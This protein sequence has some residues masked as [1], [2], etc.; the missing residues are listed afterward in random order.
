MFGGLGGFVQDQ[1]FGKQQIFNESGELYGFVSNNKIE[2]YWQYP[3]NFPVSDGKNCSVPYEKNSDDGV[4]IYS[5]DCE[6]YWSTKSIKIPPFTTIYQESYSKVNIHSFNVLK[7]IAN[8]LNINL[9]ISHT[10]YENGRYIGIFNKVNKYYTIISVD[11]IHYEVR[12]LPSYVTDSL[13]IS[14]FGK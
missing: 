7:N 3:K 4:L 14:I 1:R 11:G 13:A 9:G 8:R 5:K 6:T 10:T 12:E 2:G